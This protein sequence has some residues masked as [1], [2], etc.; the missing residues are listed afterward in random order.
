M[1]EPT[2]A[3]LVL[4]NE[5]VIA[6]QAPPVQFGVG[7]NQEIGYEAALIRESR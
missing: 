7:A 6:W 1:S 4:P 2:N 5:T 3:G